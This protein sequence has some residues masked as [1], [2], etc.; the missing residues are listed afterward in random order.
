MV[1]VAVHLA[2]LPGT[3]R[4]GKTMI[5]VTGRV[6]NLTGSPIDTRVYMSDLL[7]DGAPWPSWSLVIGNGTIDA[8]LVEL[9]PGEEASFSRELDAS[10]LP[11]GRHVLVLR[12]LGVESNPVQI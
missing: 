1:P 8:R 12:M 5:M 10:S 6:R 9:P 11:A 2:A 4:D 3:S 7:I